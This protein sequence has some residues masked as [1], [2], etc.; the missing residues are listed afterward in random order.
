[1]VLVV[2][3]NHDTGIPGVFILCVMIWYFT[4]FICSEDSKTW[5]VITW[6]TGLVTEQW[7]EFENKT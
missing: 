3:N 5:L 2:T 7:T 6:A 4:Q 1:M